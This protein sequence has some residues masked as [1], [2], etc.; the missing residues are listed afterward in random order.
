[1]TGEA[2]AG[3]RQGRTAWAEHEQER[4][5]VK[6]GGRVSA[7]TGEAQKGSWGA[8]A[9]IVAEN[10]DDVRECMCAGP[11]RARGGRS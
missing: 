4:D 3:L 6:W 7:G 11:R 1:M 9:G 10:S 8:W 2:G 5:C